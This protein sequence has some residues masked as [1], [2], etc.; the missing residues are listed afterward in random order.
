L[1]VGFEEW[2]VPVTSRKERCVSGSVSAGD[3]VGNGAPV[4]SP[5]NVKRRRRRRQLCGL[6]AVVVLLVAGVAVAGLR[7]YYSGPAKC[8]RAT[9]AFANNVEHNIGVP[10]GSD[11]RVVS[12]VCAANEGAGIKGYCGVKYPKK[13]PWSAASWRELSDGEWAQLIADTGLRPWDYDQ[14]VNASYTECGQ[15]IP[16]IGGGDD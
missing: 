14:L 9:A 5:A 4:V 7:Y 3:P 15:Q 16:I 2:L 11:Q 12:A 1:A 8:D 13:P 10:F 6:A